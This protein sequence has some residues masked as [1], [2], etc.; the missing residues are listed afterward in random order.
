MLSKEA[1]PLFS[2]FISYNSASLVIVSNSV[3]ASVILRAISSG[4]L[5][6]NIIVVYPV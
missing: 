2:T 5:D 3:L 6:S 1:A 4:V